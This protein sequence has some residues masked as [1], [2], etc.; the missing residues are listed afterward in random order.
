MAGRLH[1]VSEQR[2]VQTD[3]TEAR[4]ECLR[5]AWIPETLHL[6]GCR[7]ARAYWRMSAIIAPKPTNTPPVTRLNAFATR[8]LL[9]VAPMRVPKPA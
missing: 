1:P 7:K 3:R 6:A 8:R 2:E 5:A 9:S 4:Q